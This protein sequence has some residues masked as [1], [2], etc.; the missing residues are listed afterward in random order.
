MNRRM[1]RTNSSARNFE[2][3]PALGGG[4][5]GPFRVNRY[6]GDPAAS[7]AMSAIPPKAEVK[8]RILAAW[9]GHAR[10]SILI[11][12]V[13]AARWEHD[14]SVE[15][16]SCKHSLSLNDYDHAASGRRK[17]GAMPFS[18]TKCHAG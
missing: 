2:L 4:T 5:D 11:T 12:I 6:T 10:G 1:S 15:L 9:R 14:C 17:A 16:R 8:F 3:N 13:T 18:E 7:P